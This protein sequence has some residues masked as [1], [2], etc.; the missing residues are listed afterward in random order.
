MEETAGPEYELSDHFY[1]VYCAIEFIILIIIP[2]TIQGS[3]ILSHRHKDDPLLVSLS[4]TVL[5]VPHSLAP[6]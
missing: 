4:H 5:G 3:L 6:H 2:F 1:P